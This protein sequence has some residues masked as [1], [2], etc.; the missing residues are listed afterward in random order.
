MQGV[1]LEPV[2]A[3]AGRELGDDGRVVARGV[4]RDDRREAELAGALE[5]ALDQGAIDA[6]AAECGMHR[7]VRG[8][9]GVPVDLLAAVD[10][11]D[12]LAALLADQPAIDERLPAARFS[13]PLGLLLPGR[14]ALEVQLRRK[15]LAAERASQ[16]DQ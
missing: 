11:D 7:R 3:E 4:A 2:D 8:R 5:H 14:A 1:E 15:A 6:A 10:G 13:Q 12:P 16:A 9:V